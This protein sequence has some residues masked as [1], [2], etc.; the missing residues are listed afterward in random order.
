MDPSSSK[1]NRKRS[2]SR[3]VSGGGPQQKRNHPVDPAEQPLKIV[4]LN[5]DCLVNIF[6]RLGPIS[7]V[8]VAIA[9]EWLRPAARFVYKRQFADIEL[10]FNTDHQYISNGCRRE[11]CCNLKAC[12]QCMR[13]I[14]SSIGGVII[15]FRNL[16]NAQCDGFDQ[17][18]NSYCAESLVNITFTDKTSDHICYFEKPFVNVRTV[19]ISNSCLGNRFELFPVWFPNLQQLKLRNVVMDDRSIEM[20]LQHLQHLSVDVHN[21]TLSYGFAKKEAARLLLLC[22]QLS[23]LEIRMSADHGLTMKTLLGMIKGN[24]LITK[25]VVRMNNF[26]T[27]VLWPEIKQ[28][29]DE[30]PILIEVELKNFRF[31]ADT[32]MALVR[33]ANGLSRFQFQMRKSS[34]YDRLLSELGDQWQHSSSA[35]IGYLKAMQRIVSLEKLYE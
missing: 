32:A 21:G 35:C 27:D 26:W 8:N 34:E 17:Y 22:P 10:I 7:L 11:R 30:H 31:T 15:S 25:L 33:G 1:P 13:G 12:L 9:N 19:T 14:G 2:W 18:L 3:M 23:S 4:D 28:L 29:T 5:D 24:P 16:N 20:P 6:N